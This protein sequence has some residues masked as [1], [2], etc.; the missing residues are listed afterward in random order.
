[1]ITLTEQEVDKI[2]STLLYVIECIE[3]NKE[4]NK[5]KILDA[6]MVFISSE[7]IEYVAN[8]L[9]KDGFIVPDWEPKNV[10]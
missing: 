4:I 1:M 5:E 9:Q 8:K 10:N 2:G 6:A 3:T 7:E